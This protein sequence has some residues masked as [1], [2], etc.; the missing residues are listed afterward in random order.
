[1]G[2]L[3][4][5]VT[6]LFLYSVGTALQ[7][8]HFRGR[9]H[10][11]IAITTLVGMLALAAHGLLITQTIHHD[12]GVDFGFFKSSVLISWLI[13]FLLLGLNLKSQFKASSWAYIRWQLSPSSQP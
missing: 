2:T 12:G 11:N 10:S 9:V 4:L 13:V 7:A 3:I 6:S 1:M 5:A 8:L